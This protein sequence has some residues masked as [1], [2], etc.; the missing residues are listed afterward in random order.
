MRMLLQVNFPHGPF[1]AAV[2]DG[3]AGKRIERILQE[4][5]PEAVYFTE[6]DGRRSALVIVDVSDASAIPAFSEPWFLTFQADVKFR[7][8]MTAEDLARAD[9]ATLGKKWA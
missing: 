9:L 1:N 4:V 3:S 8:V 6:I 2:Q 5:K 7:P